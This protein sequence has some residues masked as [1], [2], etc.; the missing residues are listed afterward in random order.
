MGVS[1]EM[2]IKQLV[3][4][5]WL[6]LRKNKCL[7]SGISAKNA[8]N[9]MCRKRTWSAKEAKHH[10]L[11]DGPWFPCSLCNKKSTMSDDLHSHMNSVHLEIKPFECDTYKRLFARQ[12]SLEP[13]RHPC[14]VNAKVHVCCHCGKVFKSR[15][16]LQDHTHSHDS[17]LLYTCD[18]R[19]V[20]F[21][22]RNQLRRHSKMF[23][24]VQS[25]H[26]YV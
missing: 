7:S 8:E 20:H 22:Y 4:Y 14:T 3:I 5:W 23:V 26:A 1:A 18:E 17:S 16:S 19:L 9:H 11:D 10:K 13:G 21:R 12:K 2:E 25:E 6:L 15:G 24:L